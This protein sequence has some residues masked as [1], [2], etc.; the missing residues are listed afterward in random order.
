MLEV[1]PEFSSDS[2]PTKIFVFPVD[3]DA[4]VTNL[5]NSPGKTWIARIGRRDSLGDLILTPA[6]SLAERIRNNLKD[7]RARVIPPLKLSAI[8]ISTAIITGCFPSGFNKDTTSQQLVVT[9][10]PTVEV[11]PEWARDAKKILDSIRAA[12]TE[13][14][15]PKG[16]RA[17]QSVD[18]ERST[19]LSKD[20][21]DAD[22]SR[23]RR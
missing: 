1:E 16:Y 14:P 8:V 5:A 2:D 6:Y 13:T 22:S 3:H 11:T 20:V 17:Y 9:V 19:P 10:T 12:Q 15:S 18:I 4:V 21:Q 23:G 7:L